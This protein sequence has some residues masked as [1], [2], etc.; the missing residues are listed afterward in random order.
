[1]LSKMDRKKL[2]RQKKFEHDH[3]YRGYFTF[4]SSASTAYELSKQLNKDS[5]EMLWWRVVGVA[6]LISN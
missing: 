3:Y 5:R 2:K 4:K 6:D 1:M